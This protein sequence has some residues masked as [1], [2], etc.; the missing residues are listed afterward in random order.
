MLLVT[1]SRNFASFKETEVHYREEL[2]AGPYPGP[3]AAS[4]HP[5]HPTSLKSILI[6]S[7]HLLIDLPNS[8]FHSGCPIEILYAFLIYAHECHMPR[9][10]YRP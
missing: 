8:L 4:P 2:A 3:N 9:P 10:S 1:Q 5:L 7:S 6:L